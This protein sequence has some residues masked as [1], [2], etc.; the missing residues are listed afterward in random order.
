MSRLIRDEN[1]L[2]TLEREIKAF[3]TDAEIADYRMDIV[4]KA[5]PELLNL[6][7]RRPMWN[8]DKVKSL[9]VRLAVLECEAAR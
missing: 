4:K 7:A 1:R 3:E 6:K 8:R 9:L 5:R 2:E